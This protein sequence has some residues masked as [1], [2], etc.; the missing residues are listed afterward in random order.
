VTCSRECSKAGRCRWSVGLLATFVAACIG[1]TYGLISGLAG[2]RTTRLMMRMVD[3]L[4]AF[5]FINFVILLMVVFGR[6]FWLIFIAIGAVEWLTMA[7]VVRGQVLALKKLEFVTAAKRAE[8]A[9]GTSSSNTC[10]RM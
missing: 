10:C 4:Y 9:S 7:R 3:I 2:G 1:V 5:P 8:R 6:H